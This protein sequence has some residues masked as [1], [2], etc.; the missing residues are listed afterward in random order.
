M[1]LMQQRLRAERE[2]Y[3]ME[4]AMAHRMAWRRKFNLAKKYREGN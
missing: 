2:R 3:V 1:K 4:A